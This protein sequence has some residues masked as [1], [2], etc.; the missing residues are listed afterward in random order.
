MIM[1]RMIIKKIKKLYCIICVM[2]RKS[3]KLKISYS[4]E[5]TFFF[6]LFAV[7]ERINMEK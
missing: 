2:C 6:L 4:V 7:R 3:K 1:K 5:E